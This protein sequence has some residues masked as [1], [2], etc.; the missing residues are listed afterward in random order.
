[1]HFDHNGDHVLLN[2]SQTRDWGN[3]EYN[4]SIYFF[5]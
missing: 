5:K 4:T 2:R 1:M 3:V